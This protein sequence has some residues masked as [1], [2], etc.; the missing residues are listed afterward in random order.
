MFFEQSHSPIP[1]QETLVTTSTHEKTGTWS[2]QICT[3]RGDSSHGYFHDPDGG[4]KGDPFPSIESALEA[5]NRAVTG[6]TIPESD[7]Q[8]VEETIRASGLPETTPDGIEEDDSASDPSNP[9]PPVVFRVGREN[10]SAPLKGWLEIDG[11]KTPEFD[12]KDKLRRIL[13]D[14]SLALLF[15]LTGSD[16]SDLIR[17]INESD[18]PE[19]GPAPVD[20]STISFRRCTTCSVEAIHGYFYFGEERARV[21][22]GVFRSAET[23]QNVVAVNLRD[24][25]ISAEHAERIK[26]EINAVFSG[27]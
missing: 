23:A 17:Q 16:P 26:G 20:G 13:E 24:G 2:F 21:G 1:T 22:K 10:E 15:F 27:A 4:I 18:L 14:G 19:G 5:L 6:K 7:R 8:I 3:C 9:S 12:T 25:I 11:V